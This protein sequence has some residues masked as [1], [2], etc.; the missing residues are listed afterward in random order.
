MIHD[1]I[2]NGT[3]VRW[4]NPNDGISLNSMTVVIMMNTVFDEIR[5]S[6]H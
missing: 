3:Y 5:A 4:G 1:V 2:R 6:H